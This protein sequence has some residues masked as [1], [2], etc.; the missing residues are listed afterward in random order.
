MAI[1]IAKICRS[2]APAV[3]SDVAKR[4]TKTFFFIGARNEKG[5]RVA[6]ATGSNLTRQRVAGNDGKEKD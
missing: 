1:K 5:R 4:E 6:L 3:F 2:T